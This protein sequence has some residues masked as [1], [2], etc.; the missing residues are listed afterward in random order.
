MTALPNETTTDETMASADLASLMTGPAADVT[1]SPMEPTP[2]PTWPAKD[3]TSDSGCK[4]RRFGGAVMI[5][6]LSKVAVMPAAWPKRMLPVDLVVDDMTSDPI[7]FPPTSDPSPE[8]GRGSGVAVTYAFMTSLLRPVLSRA[9]S[10]GSSRSPYWRGAN[11][12]SSRLAF[13]M[14]VGP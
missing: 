7:D 4:S 1:L 6:G 5:V 12:G 14:E 11:V 9:L 3:S 10:M 13:G 2:L 8:D